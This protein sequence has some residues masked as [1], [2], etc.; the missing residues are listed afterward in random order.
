MKFLW[1][2][3][4]LVVTPLWAQAIPDVSCA[5]EDYPVNT[6]RAWQFPQA[7]N[8]VEV[9]VLKDPTGEQE[10]R[11][12]ITHG[13]SLISLRYKGKEMLFGQSAGASVSLFSLRRSDSPDLK[14]MNP[15]WS[16]FSPDQGDSSMGVTAT[17]TGVAC[18]GQ[19]SLRAFA[20]MEDRGADN[21]FQK[22]ALLGVVAGKISANFPPGYSTPFVIETK[23]SWTPNSSGQP[24]NLL[25]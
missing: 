5:L 12:D 17:T 18:T 21:S 9:V 25:K 13:T 11:F 4:L 2:F 7:Q 24:K 23:A 20:V 16:A 15:Y 1:C 3:A 8:K 14:G 19:L 22:R 6:V 10:A